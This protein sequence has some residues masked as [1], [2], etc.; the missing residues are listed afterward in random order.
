MSYRTQ[1][2]TAGSQTERLFMYVALP[3]CK[4]QKYRETTQDYQ[5]LK[6]GQSDLSRSSHLLVLVIPAFYDIM[7]IFSRPHIQE[8]SRQDTLEWVAFSL[9]PRGLPSLEV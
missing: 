5:R 3:Y 4:E 8:F 7:D 9:T 6:A 1:I 2:N